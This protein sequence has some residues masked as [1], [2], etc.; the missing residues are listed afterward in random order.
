[1][2][3]KGLEPN[4]YRRQFGTFLKILDI[5]IK[6]LET[7]ASF[8]T[9]VSLAHFCRSSTLVLKAFRLIVHSSQSPVG[10]VFQI[11]GSSVQP[12]PRFVPPHVQHLSL[13][14][15]LFFNI[16]FYILNL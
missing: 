15:H 8:F 14:Q 9:V 4:A 12:L 2:S 13:V 10:P 3:V 16:L 1:M 11:D 5:S 6:G 7:N